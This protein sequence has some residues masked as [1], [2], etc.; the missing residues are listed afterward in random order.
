[1]DTTRE[2]S[3]YME[4]PETMVSIPLTQYT[5]LVCIA[6]D[7]SMIRAILGR[8]NDDYIGGDATRMLKALCGLPVGKE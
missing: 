6:H 5:E 3:I 1:M 7:H 8:V 4:T 2:T